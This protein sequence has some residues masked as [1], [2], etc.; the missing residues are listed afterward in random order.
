M[1]VGLFGFFAMMRFPGFWNRTKAW[2][3]RNREV[4]P[5]RAGARRAVAS[6]A[7]ATL[8]SGM[9]YFAYGSNMSLP[10]MA[11]RAP[12]AVPLGIGRLADHRLFV[13]ADGYVAIRRRRRHVVH[14]VVWQIGAR[15]VA[16]LDRYEGVGE[17]WYV[18]RTLPV[19]LAGRSA[20]CLVYGGGRVAEGVRPR[21]RYFIEA[22]RASALAWNLPSRYIADLDRLGGRG[23]RG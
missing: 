16:A 2:R 13:T 15:D 21:R 5:G 4:R 20:V 22:V 23:F 3:G 14:G 6:T 12:G 9:L 18:R 7:P 8:G 10:E 1:P 19:R 17:G 11:L